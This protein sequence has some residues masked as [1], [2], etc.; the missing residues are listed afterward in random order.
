MLFVKEKNAFIV[1]IWYPEFKGVRL[2][3]WFANSIY[4]L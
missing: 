4:G 2:L 1:N 3:A